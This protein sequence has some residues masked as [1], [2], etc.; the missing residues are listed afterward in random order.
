VINFENDK[1]VHT[2]RDKTGKEATVTRWVD[3][4]GQQQIV[5][6]SYIFIYKIYFYL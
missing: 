1:W 3:D 6:S 4:E 5:S 2:M